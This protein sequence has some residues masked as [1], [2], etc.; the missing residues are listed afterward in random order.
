MMEVRGRVGGVG[1]SRRG[2]LGGLLLGVLGLGMRG[3]ARRASAQGLPTISP[4]GGLG[5]IKLGEPVDYLVK[6]LW[7]EKADEIKK[8]PLEGV[9]EFLLLYRKRRM[10]FVSDE[11]RRIK[12]IVTKN[13][14][15][16][17]RGNGMHVGS[18]ST[19]V[20]RAYQSIRQAS[21]GLRI[22]GKSGGEVPYDLYYY[23]ADGIA[24]TVAKEEV[25]TITVMRQERGSDR[26]PGIL[27]VGSQW[28]ELL[29][30]GNQ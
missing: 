16:P 6:Q 11:S 13:P 14:L 1:V 17:V 12:R 27:G 10:L 8:A 28:E 29:Y 9:T 19:D 24:F 2:V 5:D 25:I 26:V 7:E 18:T 3:A 21:V 30:W 23:P 4:G 20:K 15:F 22:Y